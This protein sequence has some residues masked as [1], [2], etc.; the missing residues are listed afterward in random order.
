[1]KIR[2]L[3]LSLVSFV[4]VLFSV[5]PAIAQDATAEA[6]AAATA[7][8]ASAPVSCIQDFDPQ[9]D[10]FS[11]KVEPDYSKGWTVE[12]HNTYKVVDVTTPWPGAT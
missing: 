10:Y 12:Y 11:D 7:S 2:L 9:K 4:L 6:S 3:L 5:M 8:L 1:M